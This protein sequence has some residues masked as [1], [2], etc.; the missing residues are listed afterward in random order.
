M[1]ASM[2]RTRMPDETQFCYSTAT[3]ATA[4]I[5]NSIIATFL[6]YDVVAVSVSIRRIQN[7]NSR[8]VFTN[9]VYSVSLFQIIIR[10]QNRFAIVI[11]ATCT[12]LFAFN[13]ISRLFVSIPL[14]RCEKIIVIRMAQ[15]R[16]STWSFCFPF[17]NISLHFSPFSCIRTNRA[18]FPSRQPHSDKTSEVRLLL[19]QMANAFCTVIAKSM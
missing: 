3:I 7:A 16:K 5:A 15:A 10:K 11:H 4:T 6:L 18:L 2:L 12:R 14:V 17:P 13:F 1:T 9:R 19:T 8:Q